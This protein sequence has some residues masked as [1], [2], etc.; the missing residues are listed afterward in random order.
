MEKTMKFVMD[1][2]IEAPFTG[3]YVP[4]ENLF[5]QDKDAGFPVTKQYAVD[6]METCGFTNVAITKFDFVEVSE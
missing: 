5:Y 3:D 6:Y 1:V 4:D 2:H